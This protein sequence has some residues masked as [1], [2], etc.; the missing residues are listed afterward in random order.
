MVSPR[1]I[2][3]KGLLIREA[4]REIYRRRVHR[5]EWRLAGKGIERSFAGMF[6]S[7]KKEPPSTER[8]ALGSECV[9]NADSALLDGIPNYVF[10][11][12][13]EY[14]AFN[15]PDI[16][17]YRTL[18]KARGLSPQARSVSHLATFGAKIL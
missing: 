7:I 10:V 2:G 8:A 17:E 6:S 13:S 9:A 12:H 18:V 14:R 16:A 5:R 15:I 3:G 11:A 4:C 1:G